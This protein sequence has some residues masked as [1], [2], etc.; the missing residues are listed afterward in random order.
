MSELHSRY[1]IR[2]RIF[3]LYAIRYPN[4]R[5]KYIIIPDVHLSSLKRRVL[6]AYMAYSNKTHQPCNHFLCKS[7]ASLLRTSSESP[8]QEVLKTSYEEYSEEVL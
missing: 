4:G 3:G 8:F 1:L 6:M 2:V 5:Q 7:H